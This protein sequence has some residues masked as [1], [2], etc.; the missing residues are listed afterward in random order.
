MRPLALLFLLS[1]S[2]LPFSLTTHSLS[3]ST[4]R[5]RERTFADLEYHVIF[6][7]DFFSVFFFPVCCCV[8]PP[9]PPSFFDVV[10][11]SLS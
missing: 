4:F 8:R 11:D 6:V 10:S 5:K 7:S 9:P 3:C 2:V 1:S